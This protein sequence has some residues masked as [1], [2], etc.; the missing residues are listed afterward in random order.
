MIEQK[1][2]DAIELGL[3]FVK[4]IPTSSSS[5]EQSDN[6]AK[7]L[8]NV[9]LKKLNVPYLLDSL[10]SFQ[11]T[12][13][14]KIIQ[15]LQDHQK[16]ELA[17]AIKFGMLIGLFGFPSRDQEIFFRGKKLGVPGNL[18]KKLLS[19]KQNDFAANILR[20]L[21]E[22]RRMSKTLKIFFGYGHSYSLKQEVENF[23][24]REGY[25]VFTMDNANQI[26]PGATIIEL[27][28]IG[29]SESNCA[30]ILFT[31][32][33]EISNQY[34]PR[35]NVVHELGF[36]QGKLGRDKVILLVEKGT[37]IFSNISGILYIQF[38]SNKIQEKFYD[39]NVLLS[40]IKSTL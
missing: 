19:M 31:R 20:W 25:D 32:D 40:K 8:I 3:L 1:I 35:Q 18:L 11:P 7:L 30:V 13:F 12:F 10:H 9:L 39:L 34:R 36:F 28:E 15:Y 33:D 29:S 6:I 27:L 37:Q 17:E 26:K 24:R 23:L 4:L 21:E 14:D 22:L 5:H 2:I 16:E 38:E